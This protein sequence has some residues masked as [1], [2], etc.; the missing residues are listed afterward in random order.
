MFN[1]YLND[2]FYVLIKT[3]ACNFA[4]D[5][6]LSA[7][8]MKLEDLFHNLEDD[9]LTAI[10]WFEA[11][12][13]KLNEDK[14]HF[15]FGGTVEFMFT[16]VG[17]EI[18]WESLSEKLLGVTVDKDLNFNE[19]LSNICKKVSCK[20]TALGR[21]AKFLPFHKRRILMK[22]F[23]ESQFSY[24]PLV[25]MFCS[26][27]MN[28]KIN[29]LHERALRIV[30]NN[31]RSTYEELLREDGSLSV[32][33]RNIH[34]LATEMYK[35]RHDLCPPFIKDLFTYNESR[36]KFLRPNVRTVKMGDGSI[37]CFGPIVWNTMLPEY[38]KKSPS[39]NIFKERIK[40]WVPTKCKCRL[41][42]DH[43]N[44]CSCNICGGGEK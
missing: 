10:A 16:K 14:C 20:I 34:C 31:Y 36:N 35:V 13:M 15:L 43:N 41:C 21:I 1:I 6:T 37:R 8:D 32:H 28:K 26:K 7:C 5:T 44:D 3:H 2:L 39:L 30:Y 23:I 12:Y 38:V 11:N 19:H 18:I 40:S 22:T 25:W 17:D 4:D 29:R 9:T 24:C 42:N 27:K 33:H